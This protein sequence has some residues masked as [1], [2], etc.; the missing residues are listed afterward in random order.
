MNKLGKTLLLAGSLA[1]LLSC[2]ASPTGRKRV[3]LYD[4]AKMS[5]LGAQSFEEIKQQE[6]IYSDQATNDYVACVANAVTAEIPG[7]YGEADWEVVVFDSEQVNAFALPG[8]HI[9]VYTG[10]IKVAE[11]PDQ[12]ATVIGHEISHVLAEHSN[13]R[14]SQNQIAGIGTTVAAIAI[15]VSDN[16]EHKG[17]AMAALGLGVQYGVLLPYGRTQESEADLMGLDLMASAGF[18]PKASVSLWQNMAKAGGGSVPE[19]LSTHPS[20]QTRISDLEQR[21][22]RAT[23]L[24]KQAIAQGKSPQC[25]RPASFND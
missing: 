3:L 20:N 7:H 2:S 1:V 14:L 13:E 4:D 6:K 18:D 15:G 12:L 25:L 5:A 21:M 9:G 8:A 16:I 22:A 24:Q 10:L 19:F 23:Q 17:L 11:T